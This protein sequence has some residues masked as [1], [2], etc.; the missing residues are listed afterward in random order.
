VGSFVNLRGGDV[1]PERV[2][3]SEKKPIR[4]FLCDGRNDNRGMRP[5]NPV[6]DQRLDWF[7]QNVRLMKALTEKGYDVNYTWGM[8]LH[9]QKFGGAILPDM[10]RW[11]WRDGPV[12]TDPNDK[13]E[14]SF[15][16]P[17]N[18]KAQ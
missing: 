16:A 8:N 7:Y 2:L 4:I 10:M 11:L 14:R 9:G 18:R 13:V 5:D 1:Y 17:A 15:R 3:A 12:S 6:Y